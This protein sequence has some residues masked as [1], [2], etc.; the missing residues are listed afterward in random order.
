MLPM[1][2]GPTGKE[3]MPDFIQLL[4]RSIKQGGTPIGKPP[5]EASFVAYNKGSRVPITP[6]L[7]KQIEH[8]LGDRLVVVPDPVT[9]YAVTQKKADQ[10]GLPAP[11][12]FLVEALS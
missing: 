11:R 12:T 6:T 4:T 7:L 3:T 5:G 10:I 9:A 1:G 2:H 8:D